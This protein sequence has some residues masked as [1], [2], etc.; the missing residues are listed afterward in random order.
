MDATEDAT[1]EDAGGN[2]AAD[3]RACDIVVL[4]P[5]PERPALLTTARDATRLPS[6][7][8]QGEYSVAAVVT[9]IET[10]LGG[11]AP[12]LRV[13]QRCSSSDGEPALVVA[14]LET[15]GHDAPDG[16]TWTDWSGLRLDELQPVEGRDALPDW[17]RRREAGPTPLDPPWAHPG[18]FA[19]ASRWMV[20]QMDALGSPALEPPRQVYSWGISMVLRAPTADG[21]MFLKC[22]ARVFAREAAHTA[23]LAA[24]TPDLVTRVAAIEPGEGWLLMYDHGPRTVGD[25]PPPSWATGLDVY[26]RIQRVWQ[27][28]TDEL[29]R[30]GV[31]ARSL[32][33]LAGRL[34]ALAET[35]LLASEL[36]AT[37]L[38]AWRAAMPRFIAACER[39]DA[40]GPAPTV[41]HGDLHPWNVAATPSGPRV[42]DWSDTAISHPFLDLAVYTTRPKEVDVRRALRD[43]YLAHWADE[44]PPPALA[45]AGELAI[46]VGTLYQV[47]LYVRILASLDPDDQGGLA[48]AAG[49]WARAAIQTLDEG[50]ALR[51]PGHA[52][53]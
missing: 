12:L 16:F 41:S 52:D 38:A 26:A 44:L 36:T 32:R 50:I 6:T 2:E 22:G 24:A 42:F 11:T 33:D 45:E 5:H 21:P 4:V 43:A 40:I 37:D 7:A 23:L 34:P 8:I 35:G 53:A 13:S 47:E 48:G 27:P 14:D 10:L 25:D 3:E 51:R 28:R 17:I 46:V 31:E 19:R 18:W 1:S 15:V 9:A 30:H 49:S 39:L 20:E 29:A